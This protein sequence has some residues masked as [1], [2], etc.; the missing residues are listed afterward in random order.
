[1]ISGRVSEYQSCIDELRRNPDQVH[2]VP[3]RATSRKLLTVCIRNEDLGG[4][5][6]RWSGI[7]LIP[8]EEPGTQ[9]IGNWDIICAAE[10]ILGC[11]EREIGK[12]SAEVDDGLIPGCQ[13]K[14]L[15]VSFSGAFNSGRPV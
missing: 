15:I 2:S 13:N 5:Y 7:Q 6:I 4:G 12:G 10:V 9:Y 14:K 8:S 1:L 3:D 11:C